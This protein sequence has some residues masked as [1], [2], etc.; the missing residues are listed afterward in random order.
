MFKITLLGLYLIIIS[1]E[2]GNSGIENVISD[3]KTLVQNSKVK[4]DNNSFEK[5]LEKSG[6][7]K[8]ILEYYKD[9]NNNEIRYLEYKDN[10]EALLAKI[11]MLEYINN[12]RIKYNVKNLKLD[13]LASR[14]ANKM[15][16]EAAENDFIGHWNMRGEKPYHRY[17][18][19]GGVDHVSENASAI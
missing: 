18:L 10:D 3:T 1:C 7:D 5:K 17:A 11:V 8:S 12:N 16:L 15:S 9:L 13:I 4:I 6:I 19:A 2:T 14:V